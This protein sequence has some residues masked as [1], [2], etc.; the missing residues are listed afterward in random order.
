MKQRFEKF[1]VVMTFMCIGLLIAGIASSNDYEKLL[2]LKDERIADYQKDV[3]NLKEDIES[4][5][6]EN[7]QLKNK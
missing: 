3:E 1:T 6:L 2:D 4:L 5:K 7:E